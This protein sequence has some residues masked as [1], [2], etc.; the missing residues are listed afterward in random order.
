MGPTRLT[1]LTRGV[2]AEHGTQEVVVT[3]MDGVSKGK[4]LVDLN[5]LASSTDRVQ[6]VE[7]SVTVIQR[8]WKNVEYHFCGPRIHW[9]SR[10]LWRTGK[11]LPIANPIYNFFLAHGK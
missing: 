8:R 5:G 6:D 1:K 10:P 11:R 3:G 9:V 2:D 7:E 4:G